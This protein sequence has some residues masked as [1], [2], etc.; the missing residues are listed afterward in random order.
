MPW[1]VPHMPR[2]LLNIQIH[3]STTVNTNKNKNTC[4]PRGKKCASTCARC[5]TT[6]RVRYRASRAWT[7]AAESIIPTKHK[8]LSEEMHLNISFDG[9]CWLFA[10]YAVHCSG[11]CA[12]N[13]DCNDD[14]DGDDDEVGNGSPAYSHHNKIPLW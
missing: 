10:L 4:A 9:N 6:K 2:A 14:D 3:K 5:T 12:D 1:L 8:T 7:R 13:Y 11:K